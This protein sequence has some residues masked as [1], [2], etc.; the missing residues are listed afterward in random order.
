MSARRSGVACL[1]ALA[2]LACSGPQRPP[3][4][5]ALPPLADTATHAELLRLRDHPD[6]AAVPVLERILAR[7]VGDNRIERH[8]AT[9]ALYAI[10]TPEARRALSEHARLP[11]LDGRQAFDF[12]FHWRMEPTLRDGFLR[13]V[14]LQ[15]AG[16]APA[17]EL[18]R[19]DATEH[20]VLAFEIV[21]RNG[22]NA[23]MEVMDPA[24]R[25]GEVLVFREV[26]GHVGCTTWPATC[27][28]LGATRITLGPG[29]SRVARIEVELVPYATLSPMT[30]YGSPQGGPLGAKAGGYEYALGR[31]GLYEVVARWNE[32][33]GRSVSAPMRVEL[34]LP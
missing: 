32:R 34:H 17:L 22:T 18:R 3:R 16:V 8:A 1:A 15:D 13:D 28:F 29:D 7:H 2:L 31:P 12:A 10:G 30:T 27:E 4:A 6:P 25:G 19:A 21:V 14:V 11:D 9:Q 33:T 5:P 23:P 20:G 26:A 24:R